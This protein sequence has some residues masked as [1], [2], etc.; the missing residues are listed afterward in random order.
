MPESRFEQ[1]RE[2]LGDLESLDRPSPRAELAPG[3]AYSAEDVVRLLERARSQAPKEPLWR[4]VRH[5]RV[6]RHHAEVEFHGSMDPRL[7]PVGEASVSCHLY[8]EEAKR[9]AELAR[10]DPNQDMH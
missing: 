4:G 3:H 8:D 1:E 6:A 5:V 10:L 2:I 9:K 7:L